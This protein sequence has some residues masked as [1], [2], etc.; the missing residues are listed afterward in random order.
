CPVLRHPADSSGGR[1]RGDHH[2][3]RTG[4][5][6]GLAEFRARPGRP[7]RASGSPRGQHRGGGRGPGRGQGCGGGGGRD[8]GGGGDRVLLA[9]DQSMVRGALV[10]LLG[11][12]KDIAVVAQVE[13]GDRIVPAALESR[14]DVALLDIDLPGED[15]LT[16]AA[17]L[18][19]ALPMCRVIILTTFGRVGS[20]RRALK[21]GAVG[22]LVKDT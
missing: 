15:G 16:A 19:K 2:R 17:A 7:G 4:F 1:N 21:G 9:E 8:G 3:R 14:P 18:C 10:A 13:R 5:R 11:L 20:L 12:E 22:V 6:D